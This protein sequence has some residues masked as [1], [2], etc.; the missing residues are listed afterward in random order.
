MACFPRTVDGRLGLAFT[1]CESSSQGHRI[2]AGCY[3][4]AVSRIIIG[5]VAQD[6]SVFLRRLSAVFG[7][8]LLEALD[9]C[10]EQLRIRD[11]GC[12]G[13]HQ[14]QWLDSRVVVLGAFVELNDLSGECGN[15]L[16]RG[17]GSG[18]L[19]CRQKASSANA[20]MGARAERVPY[21]REG[22]SHY[23]RAL[24]LLVGRV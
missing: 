24:R 13:V 22:L 9:H 7:L 11:K 21:R 19:S 20:D 10:K 15:R 8:R 14:V 17:L 5:F 1:I 18:D 4:A 3:I 2:P 6:A 16:Y 12:L 23:V